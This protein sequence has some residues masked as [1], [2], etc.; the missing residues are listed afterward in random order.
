MDSCLRY[1]PLSDSFFAYTIKPTEH[2]PRFTK[3]STVP[4]RLTCATRLLSPRHSITIT[5][6]SCVVMAHFAHWQC[7]RPGV[8][9]DDVVIFWNMKRNRYALRFVPIV[10]SA[11]KH[12]V[13][14]LRHLTSARSHQLIQV[15]YM[16]NLI[17]LFN[18]ESVKI[19]R[20]KLCG[21][22]THPVGK[23][24]VLIST[25]GDSAAHREAVLPLPDCSSSLPFL[26]NNTISASPVGSKVG[27]VS[28]ASFPVIFLPDVA[29]LSPKN[30]QHYRLR[31]ALAADGMPIPEGSSLSQESSINTVHQELLSFDRSSTLLVAGT[32]DSGSVTYTLSYVPRVGYDPGDE[33]GAREAYDAHLMDALKSMNGISRSSLDGK[34]ARIR[35]KG[36]GNFSLCEASGRVAYWKWTLFGDDTGVLCVDDYV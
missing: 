2:L 19:W 4:L 15:T 9:G 36:I 21:K 23:D 1:S 34:N 31:V 27:F 5:N 26:Y 8:S 3:L 28:P 12:L 13:R 11:G 7:T 18:D 25:M 24:P 20:L 32:A 35:Q 10:G 29:A 22:S 17:A 6:D 33:N 30:T 14:R 16:G